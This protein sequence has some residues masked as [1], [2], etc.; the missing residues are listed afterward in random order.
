MQVVFA[1]YSDIVKYSDMPAVQPSG[2]V[3][4]RTVHDGQPGGKVN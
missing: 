2:K 4:Q 3:D 1:I